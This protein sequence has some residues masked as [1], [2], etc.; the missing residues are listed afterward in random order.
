MDVA[1]E[2]SVLTRVVKRDGNELIEKNFTTRCHVSC[3]LQSFKC[4]PLGKSRAKVWHECCPQCL[5]TIK[6]PPFEQPCP[7]H[8]HSAFQIEILLMSTER[9]QNDMFLNDCVVVYG[10]C[11][12]YYRA[13]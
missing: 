13:A 7:S 2:G 8:L 5:D 3:R 12:E 4:S 9:V 1:E 11:F 6:V 10:I